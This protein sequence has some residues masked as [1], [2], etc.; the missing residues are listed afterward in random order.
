MAVRV[1]G[2][3]ADPRRGTSRIKTRWRRPA[4]SCGDH[5]RA[6][7]GGVIIRR[8]VGRGPRRVVRHGGDGF[9][10]ARD[11][12]GR[13]AAARGRLRFRA[14]RRRRGCCSNVCG[15][16]WTRCWRARRRIRP[17]RRRRWRGP[18]EEG[19]CGTCCGRSSRGPPDEARGRGDGRR[20]H[21]RGWM[22]RA[23]RRGSRIPETAR[24]IA[25][26]GVRRSRLESRT[27]DA[28]DAM[29]EKFENNITLDSRCTNFSNH[30]VTVARSGRSCLPGAR[31]SF[32]SDPR[33]RRWEARRCPPSRSS[34]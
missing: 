1:R 16:S 22:F 9:D 5:R 24:L 13:G 14:R 20:E 8:R 29:C 25:R 17:R 10:R 21:E 2:S 19:A 12:R 30:R 23:E 32:V 27:V 31:P 28:V 33:G 18:R 3:R 4:C 26:A 6:G 34:A 11:E 15:G 7:R